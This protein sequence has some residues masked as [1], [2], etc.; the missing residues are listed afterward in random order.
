[1]YNDI[2]FLL[3]LYRELGLTV[4][5]ELAKKA[6][7]DAINHHQD[8][9]IFIVYSNS[10][11]FYFC[12]GYKK[13]PLMVL[14]NNKNIIISEKRKNFLYNQGP[15][16]AFMYVFRNYNTSKS[17]FQILKKNRKKKCWSQE[18]TFI[19]QSFVYILDRKKKL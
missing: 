18:I 11:N 9:K 19:E 4:K 16:A 1:M 5:L 13:Y 12:I 6:K 7:Q 14:G 3:F 2:H 8:K 15:V 10:Q 17:L